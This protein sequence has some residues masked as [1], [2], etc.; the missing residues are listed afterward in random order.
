MFVLDAPLLHSAVAVPETVLQGS[1]N[2]R[3]DRGWTGWP[4]PRYIQMTTNAEAPDFF[5][6]GKKLA[7]TQ[8]F[9]SGCRRSDRIS[10]RGQ[11]RA[12]I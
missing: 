2:R 1:M 5:P 7:G 3:P 8:R 10:W 11:Y 9:R 12:H 4:N 6:K